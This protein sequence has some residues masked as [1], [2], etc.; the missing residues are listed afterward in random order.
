VQI[1]LL[2]GIGAAVIAAFALVA[3]PASAAPPI[4]GGTG[5]DP[6]QAPPVPIVQRP[7][8]AVAQDAAEYARQFGVPLAEAIR[9][10]RAQEE[11]VAATD[12]IRALYQGRL[13]GI[14]IEHVPEYRIVVLLTGPAPVPSETI[15]AGGMTVPI[16]YRTG[17]VATGAEIVA[18]IRAHAQEIRA[19]LPN[20]VGMG[21]DPRTG[22]FVLMVR[23]ADAD[24]HGVAEIERRLKEGLRLPARVR[25]LDRPDSNASTEG[26]ARVEGRDAVTGR[27]GYCTT[28]FVVTDGARTGIVTAAHC[29]DT[30]TYFDPAGGKTELSFGGQ[31]GWSF[32]DVQLHVTPD[33]QKPLFYADTKKTAARPLTGAR[34]RDSTR[35]GD[36]VCHRG[37][38]TGYSCAEVELVDYAPPGDLCGGPCA[39]VWVTVAGPSC[40]S[41]DSGGPVFSGGTAFG[42]VKGASYDRKGRCNF[43]YYMSTDYLPDGW[44]LLTAGAEPTASARGARPRT[45]AGAK[46]VAAGRP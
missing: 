15:R 34:K 7:A 41:G 31:W 9:R 40:G 35:A 38:R 2:R 18:A 28:G 32:Q 1:G 21:L 16:V 44:S 8:E 33:A 30:V 43:Y 42:I 11:S 19:Q 37:E 6:A 27:P 26:G 10:L 29:P 14:A 4:V 36:F 39:P 25:L 46:P 45:S 13:V 3:A 20:A 22:E 5:I 23:R 24:R 17:A 12:R